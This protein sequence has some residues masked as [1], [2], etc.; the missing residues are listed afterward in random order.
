[1]GLS[2]TVSKA[3][4]EHTAVYW[5]AEGAWQIGRGI[6]WLELPAVQCRL[7]LKVSVEPHVGWIAYTLRQ[8]FAGK[9][10]MERCPSLGCGEGGLERRLA[11]MDAFLTCDA[12][13]VAHASIAKAR[14]RAQESGY[15]I[16]RYSVQD[17]N[18]LRLPVRCYDTIWASHAIHHLERLEHVFQQTVR[19][20]R[21]EGMFIMNEYVGANRFQ[22][23]KRQREVIHACHELL[24]ASYRRLTP[25]ALERPQTVAQGSDWRSLA[26]LAVGKLHDSDLLAAIGRRLR[27]MRAVRSSYLPIGDGTNLPTERSVRAVDPSEAVRSAEIERLLER[28]FRIIQ[29][30][31]LGGS[32]LQS[33]LVGIAGN[34]QDPKG[35][36][37]L[38]LLFAI[39]DT[40]IE[41]GD[42]ASD[43]VYIVATPL[44]D[45]KERESLTR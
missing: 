22:F 18:Q 11:A 4:L 24:P 21:P 26:R 6:H 34:F 45:P 32:I 41:N 19:A 30:K 15:E 23:P 20:L 16:I 8:H 17:V 44:P 40:L 10:P 12:I 35:E 31:E 25:A 43:F 2:L 14:M 33:L 28:H 37:L 36:R 38:E 9:L 42:L 7:N 1:V 29:R 39:E 3:D 13:A 5:S 27:R